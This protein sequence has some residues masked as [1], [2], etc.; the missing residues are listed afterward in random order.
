[1]LS[2][3]TDELPRNVQ[4]VWG[5]Y[6][7]CRDAAY[8][9]M[10]MLPAGNFTK[11]SDVFRAGEFNALVTTIRAPDVKTKTFECILAIYGQFTAVYHPNGGEDPT[12]FTINKNKPLA[13]Y[14]T[15]VFPHE[16]FETMGLVEQGVFEASRN[17]IM[18]LEAIAEPLAQGTPF[19]NIPDT[20][21]F[22][23]KLFTHISRLDV[24]MATDA[25]NLSGRVERAAIMI[26]IHRAQTPAGS[27][28]Y[29]EL[30]VQF[31]MLRTKLGQISGNE[32]LAALD[33]RVAT[34]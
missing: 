10:T 28:H 4:S 26:A 15:Y 32:A 16:T 23:E 8:A 6:C 9:F 13:G 27:V 12:A 29:N 30:D 20:A 24:W 21:S 17:F 31:N 3:L 2:I 19:A 1:M 33:A 25:P 34:L 14:M 11:P 7:R 18:S 5:S 22:V